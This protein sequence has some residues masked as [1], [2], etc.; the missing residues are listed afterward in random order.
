VRSVE[1]GF[2]ASA[3]VQAQIDELE[4]SLRIRE[5]QIGDLE[6]RIPIRREEA[7]SLREDIADLDRVVRDL[8]ARMAKER[9][10]YNDWLA[11]QPWLRGRKPNA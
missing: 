6:L 1:R 5:G 11:S 3:K 2:A 8:Y 7:Q 4:E 10:S 9:T